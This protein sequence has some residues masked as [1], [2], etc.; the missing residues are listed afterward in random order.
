MTIK[1]DPVPL[2]WDDLPPVL[3]PADLVALLR[4]SENTVYEE[5]R[6]GSLVSVACKVGR[7]YRV[8]RERLRTLLEGQ[9]TVP[10]SES[11]ADRR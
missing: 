8:S 3:T 10:T 5:L 11:R 1:A 2:R 6:S 9:P 4:L 7:Q